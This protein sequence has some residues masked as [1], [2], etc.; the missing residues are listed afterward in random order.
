MTRPTDFRAEPVAWLWEYIGSDPYPR[1]FSPVARSLR[2]ADPANPPFPDDWRPIAPLY[3][4]PL[5][6]AEAQP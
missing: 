1:K 5:P 3:A 2:E 4:L 6:A